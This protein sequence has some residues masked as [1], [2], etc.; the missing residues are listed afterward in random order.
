VW[1][2]RPSHAL[3]QAQNKPAD[4]QVRST[5]RVYFGGSPKY[6]SK[7]ISTD[8]EEINAVNEGWILVRDEK[9]NHPYLYKKPVS[10]AVTIDNN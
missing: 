1:Q 7:W 5:T 6:V 3:A 2:G 4:V 10:S 8:E 9:E